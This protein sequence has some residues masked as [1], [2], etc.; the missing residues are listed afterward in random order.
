MVDCKDYEKL[1][2]DFLGDRLDTDTTEGFIR[3]I[4][5]CPECMEEL[6]IQ[7]LITEGMLRL[8]K[9]GTFELTKELRTLIE[10]NKDWIY[11]VKCRRRVHF[12]SVLAG[13]LVVLAIICMVIFL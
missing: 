12:A 7:F 11:L 3:H 10:D 1:I 5:N 2:P 9:G 4:E 8:E 6:S 13:F